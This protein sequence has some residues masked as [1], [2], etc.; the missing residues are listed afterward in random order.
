MKQWAIKRGDIPEALKHAE[1][2]FQ[3]HPT[4]SVYEEVRSLAQQLGSWGQMC[5][6]LIRRIEGEKQYAL[7]MEIYLLEEE[8]DAALNMVRH[9]PGLAG[10]WEG[11]PLS[12]RVARAAEASRPHEAIILYVAGVERLI[13]A[14]DR[15]NYAQAVEYLSRVREL[16]LR[17]GEEKAW[18]SFIA[19]LRDKN[20]RLS[21]LKEELNRAGL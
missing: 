21:A 17:L 9:P 1:Q 6:H 18:Q 13:K 14:R 8:I 11:S 4:I 7:L 20:R 2:L 10:A 19:D 12:L 3:I 15:K 5:P 16:Y